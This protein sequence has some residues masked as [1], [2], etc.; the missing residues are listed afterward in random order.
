[1]KGGVY[2]MLT[3]QRDTQGVRELAERA[4]PAIQAEPCRHVQPQ[5]QLLCTAGLRRLLPKLSFP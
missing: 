4:A 5:V 1:M 2:R 3:D